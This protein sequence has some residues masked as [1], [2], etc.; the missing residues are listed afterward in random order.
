MRYRFLQREGNP[1]AARGLKHKIKWILLR[2][3]VRVICLLP[4]FFGLKK[5]RSMFPI[6]L[7]R[8]AGKINLARRL[9]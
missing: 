8:F 1:G 4:F 6:T 5:I 2:V 3:R 7:S 9:G